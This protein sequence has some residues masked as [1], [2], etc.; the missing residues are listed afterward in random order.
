MINNGDYL[1]IHNIIHTK[2]ASLIKLEN[3]RYLR[4]E[5][6]INVFEYLFN[7]LCCKLPITEDNLLSIAMK[8]TRRNKDKDIQL[9]K[10][11]YAD[12]RV[13]VMTPESLL[14]ESYLN[15]VQAEMVRYFSTSRTMHE[16]KDYINT[17]HG[18]LS[19]NAFHSDVISLHEAIHEIE[20]SQR[21]II[22]AY[23]LQDERLKKIFHRINAAPIGITG[24]PGS[25]KTTIAMM[26][27]GDLLKQGYNGLPSYLTGIP[28]EAILHKQQRSFERLSEIKT[29][30][31]HIGD[32]T[33]NPQEVEELI[34]SFIITHQTH[35]VMVDFIQCVKKM[36]G[37]DSL[38]TIEDMMERMKS[39]CTDERIPVILLSQINTA[40]VRDIL[41]SKKRLSAGTEQGG[42]RI[43]Q[44][45]R[46]AYYITPIESFSDLRTVDVYCGKGT[47]GAGKSYTMEFNGTN[48]R[49]M[50]CHEGSIYDNV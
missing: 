36:R 23:E 27:A 44:L 8:S 15:C 49:P 22:P 43:F 5:Y 46:Y 1:Y 34:R 3:A 38:Q 35:F 9:I 20:N 11:I 14:V 21:P 16:T 12:R 19:K 47:Y 26:V 41:K 2:N 37:H 50:E 39:I 45:L 10:L 48:G 18:Q 33:R 4:D 31:L 25:G 42:G 40:D 32:K 24:T 13:P 28:K 6:L 29:G 17:L 30:T 7:L